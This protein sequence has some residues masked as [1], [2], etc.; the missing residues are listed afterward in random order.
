MTI[1]PEAIEAAFEHERPACKVGQMLLDQSPENRAVLNDKLAAV[2]RY[3]NETIGRVFKGLGLGTFGKDIVR[4]HRRREC[5]CEGDLLPP[6]Q[7]D[8]EREA[9]R[10]LR[11][12]RP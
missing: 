8:R 10:R 1:S 12:G 11:G 4:L 2:E 7:A 9:D 3:S 6:T 5:K